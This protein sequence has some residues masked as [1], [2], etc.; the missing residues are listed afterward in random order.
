MK[1]WAKSCFFALLPSRFEEYITTKDTFD[2]NQPQIS[3]FITARTPSNTYSFNHPQQRAITNSILS[4]LVI[5]CNLPLSIIEHPSFQHFLTVV[6]SRYAT[7]SC[8]TIT[9]NL[10]ELVAERRMKLKSDLGNA[11]SVSVNAD[12]WSER[13][14]GS[15]VQQYTGWWLQLMTPS[16]WSWLYWHAAVSK[17]P[18]L[19]RGFVRSFSRCVKIS[20]WEGSS[21]PDFQVKRKKKP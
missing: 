16:P 5:D 4:D 18:I 2:I 17:D 20:S 13:W 12:I 11:D 1:T 21:P 15:L 9:T 8:R 7:V 3:Q 14:G 6:D 19:V 10:D